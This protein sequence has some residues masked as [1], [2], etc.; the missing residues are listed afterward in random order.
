MMCFPQSSTLLI[1]IIELCHHWFPAHDSTVFFKHHVL[2]GCKNE[3]DISSRSSSLSVCKPELF[4]LVVFTLLVILFSALHIRIFIVN[5][6]IYSKFAFIINSFCISEK[7][8]S[9]MP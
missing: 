2:V 4:I 6:E 1:L 8:G 7:I 5:I 3:A 9:M